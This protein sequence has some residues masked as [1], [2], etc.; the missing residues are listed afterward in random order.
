MNARKFTYIIFWSIF[1]SI[2]VLFLLIV[3]LSL[4]DINAFDMQ[5]RTPAIFKVFLPFMTTY[6][7]IITAFIIRNRNQAGSASR[8]LSPNYVWYVAILLGLHFVLLAALLLLAGFS[9]LH[10][11]PFIWLIGIVE[12]AFGASIVLVIRDL[13]HVPKAPLTKSENSSPD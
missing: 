6:M 3:I 13:F 4:P 8:I 7:G 1:I 5:L 9:R 12:T 2:I 10:F 11:N